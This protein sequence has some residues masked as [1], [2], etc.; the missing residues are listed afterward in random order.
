MSAEA[1]ASPT[2]VGK[3]SEVVGRLVEAREG[4]EVQ[5]WQAEASQVV[6]KSMEVHGRWRKPNREC[7]V[8][9]ESV[10]KG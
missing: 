4:A 9:R 2:E 5:I 6:R 10:G 1:G 3:V 8:G 7:K